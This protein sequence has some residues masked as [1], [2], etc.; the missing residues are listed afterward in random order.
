MKLMISNMVKSQTELDAATNYKVGRNLQTK[1]SEMKN[2]V[3]ISR[4]GQSRFF[5]FTPDDFQSAVSA[6][7][8]DVHKQNGDVSTIE[9]E[10]PLTAMSNISHKAIRGWVES[11]FGSIADLLTKE[12]HTQ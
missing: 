10:S 5:R 1:K 4:T 3:T 8:L 11:K 7:V 9:E 12:E 6:R 2:L